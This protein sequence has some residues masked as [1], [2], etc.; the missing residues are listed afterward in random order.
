M[1]NIYLQL[2]W[3]YQRVRYGYDDT[4]KWSFPDYFSQFIT[5]LKEFCEEEVSKKD[6]TTLNPERDAVYKET[7]RLIGEYDMWNHE[8]EKA[9]WKFVGENMGYYWN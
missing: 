4:I 9:L 6:H 3:A 8:S 2:K 5:P 1:K 7:L